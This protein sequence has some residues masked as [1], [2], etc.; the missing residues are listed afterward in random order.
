MTYVCIFQYFFNFYFQLGDQNG[1]PSQLRV[2]GIRRMP[3]PPIRNNVTTENLTSS[4]E[5]LGLTPEE[6]IRFGLF[7][8]VPDIKKLYPGYKYVSVVKKLLIWFWSHTEAQAY[9]GFCSKS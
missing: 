5:L 9:L 7:N 2:D 1:A 8:G 3:L 6:I 4:E